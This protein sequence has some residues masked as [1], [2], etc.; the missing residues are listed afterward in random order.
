MG[1]LKQMRLKHDRRDDFQS[2][3]IVV[4]CY[5]VEVHE[6]TRGEYIRQ[7]VSLENHLLFY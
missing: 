7:H 3:F 2:I 6:N 1:D 4:I 5:D